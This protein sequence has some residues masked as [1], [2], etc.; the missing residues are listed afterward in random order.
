VRVVLPLKLRLAYLIKLF[1]TELIVTLVR[2][3]IGGRVELCDRCL[4]R[5]RF[6][7]LHEWRSLWA[8]ARELIGETVWWTEVLQQIR[9]FLSVL[10]VRVTCQ[11]TCP[12]CGETELESISSVH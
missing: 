7:L 5:Q 11:D 4:N 6:E 9:A 2:A 1:W 8:G 3:R 10:R 12:G